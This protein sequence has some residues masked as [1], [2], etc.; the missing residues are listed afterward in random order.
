RHPGAVAAAVVEHVGIGGWIIHRRLIEFP[1]SAGMVGDDQSGIAA[2]QLQ[3]VAAHVSGAW[4]GDDLRAR[5]PVAPLGRD[6]HRHQATSCSCCRT[7]WRSRSVSEYF[8]FEQR[9]V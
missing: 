4:I 3:T 1:V 9:T 5:G 7:T 2:A 6:G 8:V